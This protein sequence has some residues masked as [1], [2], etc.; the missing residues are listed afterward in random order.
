[1]SM[2]SKA[3]CRLAVFGLL[4]AGCSNPIGLINP[5]EV[6]RKQVPL[7]CPKADVIEQAASYLDFAEGRTGDV[8]A[9]R[10][11]VNFVGLEGECRLDKE[12]NLEL[13]LFM[14]FLAQAGVGLKADTVTSAPWYLIVLHQE[15]DQ[16]AVAAR[17][18]FTQAIQVYRDGDAIPIRE[19][20]SI[21]V[22][23]LN[24]ETVGEYRVIGGFMLDDAQWDFNETNPFYF[25]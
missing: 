22:P 7:N 17:Q 2:R 16:W 1:M 25:R 13:N 9:V 18:Q 5:S 6:L 19:Q 23:G 12:G 4:L 24:E 21:T 11:A 3:F 8:N 10:Y 15:G 20:F 14:L